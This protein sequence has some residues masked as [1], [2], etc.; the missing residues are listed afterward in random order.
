MLE[1][2]MVIAS[3]NTEYGVRMVTPS[4]LNI[5]QTTA[6]RHLPKRLSLP[7]YSTCML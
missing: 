5:T 7:E 2:G 6:Y 4:P 1:D 3:N